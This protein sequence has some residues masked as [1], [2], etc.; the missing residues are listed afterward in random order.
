MTEMSLNRTPAQ[1]LG[2]SATSA[3]AHDTPA[4]VSEAALAQ[5]FPVAQAAIQRRKTMI[6]ALR[7]AVLV[8]VLGGWELSAR[9]KWIDPFFIPCP[10]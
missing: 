6:I 5:E 2:A 1:P 7:L 9:M 8:I 3:A 10:A 4:A